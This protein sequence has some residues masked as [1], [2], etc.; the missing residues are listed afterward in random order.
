MAACGREEEAT[1]KKNNRRRER[2]RKTPTRAAA[3]GM[4]NR[5]KY[6]NEDTKRQKNEEKAHKATRIRMEVWRKKAM[7]EVYVRRL[8]SSLLLLLL[9]RLGVECAMTVDTFPYL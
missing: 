3:S 4:G 1:G 8:P 7:K 5:K 6:R 9:P 2:E